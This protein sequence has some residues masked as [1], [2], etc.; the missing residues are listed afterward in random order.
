L[1]F[2]EL[3]QLRNFGGH[4]LVSMTAEDLVMPEDELVGALPTVEP[5]SG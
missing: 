4:N 3:E 2:V 1:S 5:A